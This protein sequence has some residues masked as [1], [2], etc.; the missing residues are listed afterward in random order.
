MVVLFLS[1]KLLSQ[2]RYHFSKEQTL[3]KIVLETGEMQ[4]QICISMFHFYDSVT[5]EILWLYC[6]IRREK[7]Q[8][9]LSRKLAFEMFTNI[10]YVSFHLLRCSSFFCRSKN[11]ISTKNQPNLG[12]FQ[13][14][15]KNRWNFT[16]HFQKGNKILND[17]LF[18][19]WTPNYYLF[20]HIS[21]FVLE[22][23]QSI[24][25][26]WQIHCFRTA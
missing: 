25:F 11:F 12:S 2:N 13:R 15:Q 23:V 3:N 22:K 24:C 6:T 1:R 20:E 14:T 9:G 4:N 7:V 18:V 16:S 19:Y 10:D 21:L 26:V 17:I 5:N 8:I